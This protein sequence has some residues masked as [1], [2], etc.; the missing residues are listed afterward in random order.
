MSVWGL[1]VGPGVLAWRT[2]LEVIEILIKVQLTLFASSSYSRQ[3][4]RGCRCARDTCRSVN[5]DSLLPNASF[6]WVSVPIVFVR[7]VLVGF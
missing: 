5:V 6:D 2:L 4:G 3:R 1:G 7:N